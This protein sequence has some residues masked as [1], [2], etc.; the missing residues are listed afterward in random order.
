MHA[1]HAGVGGE[2]F[3][4][5]DRLPLGALAAKPPSTPAYPHTISCL[6]PSRGSHGLTQGRAS[7][8]RTPPRRSPL[9]YSPYTPA[10]SGESLYESAC[11]SA[12]ELLG[13]AT[14]PRGESELVEFGLT[15]GDSDGDSPGGGGRVFA[16]C[17]LVPEEPP[18]SSPLASPPFSTPLQQ[19]QQDSGET[20]HGNPA[21][22]SY[23]PSVGDPCGSSSGIDIDTAYAD[24]THEMHAHAS[25]AAIVSDS[26]VPNE[27]TLEDVEEEAWL[28]TDVATTS[29]MS[30][31][32]ESSGTI[33]PREQQQQRRRIKLKSGGL[34]QQGSRGAQHLDHACQALQRRFYTPV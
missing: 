1:Q 22:H 12:C 26:A 20:T 32:D 29:Q 14:P 24:S 3:A 7:A 18:L 25:S 31:G 16:T 11:E 5:A 13:D 15:T 33:S 17:S 30:G 23:T 8:N 19:S 2:T 6:T 9:Y 21:C 27:R 10:T 4:G 28:P 34:S